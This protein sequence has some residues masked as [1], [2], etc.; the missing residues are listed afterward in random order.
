MTSNLHL[1]TSRTVATAILLLALMWMP[2]F[3][4]TALAQPSEPY[5]V[6]DENGTLTFTYGS[7]PDSAFTLNHTTSG[8]MVVPE[9]FF[10]SVGIKKVVFS[11]SFAQA[12][13]T[14]C[15]N[16]FR[17]AA[18]IKII[19]DIQNL[20][21][22]QVT[23]MEGMFYGC[24]NLAMLDFFN[25]NTQNVTDMSYMFYKCQRLTELD[26]SMF[27]TKNVK[28]MRSMFRKCNRLEYLNMQNFN[29]QSVADM[30]SMFEDCAV[31][32]SIDVSSFNT[33][34]VTDMADMFFKCRKITTLDLRNFCTHSVTNMSSMFNY[35]TKLSTIYVTDNFT[36]TAVSKSDN[37]FT[38]SKALK[39]AIAYD[40]GKVT[41]DFANYTTGYFTKLVG[42]LGGQ[43]IGAVGMPLTADSLMISGEDFV[44]Y[45]P[46]RVAKAVYVRD[47]DGSKWGTLCLPFAISQNEEEC[48]FYMLACIN[49]EKAAV[50]AE[51]YPAGS[52]I[53]AGTPVIFKMNDGYTA[54]SIVAS[55]ADIA[56][57]PVADVGGEA[58][59]HLVGTF[60]KKDSDNGGFEFSTGCYLNYAGQF[61]RADALKDEHKDGKVNA[62]EAHIHAATVLGETAPRV[63]NFVA[64]GGGTTSVIEHVVGDVA[65]DAAPVEYYDAQGRRL[66][67]PQQGVVVVR[68]GGRAFKMMVK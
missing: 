8:G 3:G 61:W 67:A 37:M 46:F 12:R 28:S 44:A 58:A 48:Q 51:S 64:S 30:N 7:K 54:I 65:D 55:D 5:A 63:L 25:F 47:G 20:N 52:V 27:D 6:L 29:T 23:S 11:Q 43:K 22:E 38:D 59:D 1:A 15:T 19:E 21:T 66:S 14:D 62:M 60:T 56:Q 17:N 10:A 26:L 68:Q 45:E 16:W 50:E 40:A 33:S 13:P 24:A 53:P 2:S 49:A 57:A 36:T 4:S 42:T 35:C 39:G 32:A 18:N 41:K 9:W 34:Q 31:L